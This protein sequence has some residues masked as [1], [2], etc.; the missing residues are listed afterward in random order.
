MSIKD[1]IYTADFET[2]TDVNDCR[3]WAYSL[4]SVN[5]LDFYYGNNIED[6]FKFISNKKKNYVLYFH[7][8]KF[9]IQFIL[10]Y[11]LKNDFTWIP[12]KKERANKTFTTLISDLGQFYSLE[13]YFEVKGHKVNKCTIYDSLKLINSS[14]EEIPKDFGLPIEKLEIDYDKKREVGYKLLDN[15]IDYIKNDVEIMARALQFMF[16]EGLTKMTIGSNALAYYK[17]IM[18]NFNNY[19]PIL[20][21]E[22]DENIRRSYKGGFTYLNDVYKNKIVTNGIV[23]D[24][25][26]M[27]PWVMKDCKLPY[28]QPLYFKGKYENDKLYNLYVQSLSCSFKL[29]E[30]KLPTIQLKHNSSFVPTEYLKDSKDE[31]V[32]LT[33]T[34][35]DLELFFENYDVYDLTYHDG[36]KFKS[37]RGLFD[38]YIDYWYQVKNENKK[39]KN[40]S[41]VKIAKLMLNSLYGKFGLNPNCRSKR[42]YLDNDVVKY[43]FNEREIR[44]S[45]YIPVATFITS[46]ARCKTI[47]SSQAI[48]DYSIKKYGVDMYIYS[49]TDSI[50]TLLPVDECKKI[51]EVDDY[52]LGAWKKESEFTKAKFIR[53]KCYV[54]MYEDEKNVTVAGLPKYLKDLVNIDNFKKGLVVPGKL[55]PKN[56]KGGCVLVETNFTLKD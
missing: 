10:Y 31:I 37:V 2:T 49:D 13:I 15:E 39:L 12:N 29:K 41:K 35:L 47:R 7:N 52:K 27:Y 22:T 40:K 34:N 43:T 16:N 38:K 46:Y 11:L 24:E 33:L 3:V 50:H 25:N 21:Y 26:S 8:L 23:L 48:R 14:V 36:Y 5:N 54:E 53:Q 28:G 45:I 9:D 20:D 19:F 30:G 51:L 4:C 42:P 18:S 56:V 55:V 6:F 1:N 17:E 44:D 32:T